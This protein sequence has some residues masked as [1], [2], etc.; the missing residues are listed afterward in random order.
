LDE[1]KGLIAAGAGLVWRR[2]RILWWVF[3]VN[4][5][6]GAMGTVEAH[7]TLRDAIGHSLV[8]KMWYKGFDLPSFFTELLGSRVDLL[9]SMTNSAIFALLFFLFMLFVGGGI[10]TAYREDRRLTTEEFFGE[11]G[12]F[13]WRFV[14][15]ML[16]SLIPLAVIGFLLGGLHKLV[17]FVDDRAT[18]DQISFYV[19]V[20]GMLILGLLALA[21]RLWFDIAQTRAVVQGERKMRRNMWRALGLTRRNLGRLLL[22]YVAIGLVGWI[23]ALVGIVVWSKLPPTAVP[24]TF[25]LLE[26]IVLAQIWTRLWQRASAMVWYKRHAELV[27]A[28]VVD[29]TTPAPVE[30]VEYPLASWMP[31]ASGD[32]QPVP[33][34]AAAEPATAPNRE[35]D[36][37]PPADD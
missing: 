8:G 27:P 32:P 36:P 34:A 31:P 33:P 11:S 23:V 19:H 16:F 30:V 10:L 25:L 14:R 2:K 24:V 3:A 18:A 6:L 35:P 29:Y 5:V 37:L 13:F 7:R 12:A 15:L 21:V 1:N 4:V 20:G 9:R 26:I 17:D 22:T 28:D